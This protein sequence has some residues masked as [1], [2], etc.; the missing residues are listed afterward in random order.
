MKVIS[1]LLFVL[2]MVIVASCSS[3]DDSDA[4]Q[5]VSLDSIIVS[6][7]NITVLENIPTDTVLAQLIVINVSEEF[8]YSIVSQSPA[9]AFAVDSEGQISVADSSLFDY[10]TYP[11]ITGTVAVAAEGYETKEVAI[12]ITLEDKTE[13][14]FMTTI[15]EN[16]QL[17]DTL[18][19][20]QFSEEAEELIFSIMSQSVTNAFEVDA[21]G[22]ITVADPS[23]FVFDNNP[24]LTATIAVSSEGEAI[25]SV[26]VIVY[27]VTGEIWKGDAV[28]FT[29]TATA[30]PTKE[31]GQDR[32][33]DNVWITRNQHIGGEI[34]NAKQESYATKST[35]PKDTEWALGTLDEIGSLTFDTFRNTIRPQS[36]VGEDLVMHLIT[37]DIYLSVSFTSWL[38]GG[39]GNTGGG[40]GFTYERST[41][42][43]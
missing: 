29:K 19:Q 4:M 5:E 28:S 1:K 6:D 21:E 30:D 36:V 32:I 10:E 26:S 39:G 41:A 27:V 17:D 31:T 37:D 23:A 13:D 7:I 22:Y 38:S 25:A 12:N 3:D 35:S 16:P 24:M 20:I 2:L 14:D 40:G 15:S 34:Y 33:T 42:N 18:G 8:T 43:E 9:G 11:T